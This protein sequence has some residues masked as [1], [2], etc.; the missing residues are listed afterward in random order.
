MDFWRSWRIAFSEQ[1]LAS[2]VQSDALIDIYGFPQHPTQGD[3]RSN[4]FFVAATDVGMAANEPHLI[5]VLLLVRPEV[6]FLEARHGAFL[7]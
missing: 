1:R 5:N 2:I 6:L 4:L 7:I 3:S